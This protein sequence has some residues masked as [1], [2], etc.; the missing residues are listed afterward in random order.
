MREST[1]SQSPQSS[2]YSCYGRS[3]LWGLS[4]ITFAANYLGGDEMFALVKWPQPTSSSISTP[5]IIPESKTYDSAEGYQKA[6]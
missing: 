2:I 1:K 5:Q 4:N 6:R 3:P